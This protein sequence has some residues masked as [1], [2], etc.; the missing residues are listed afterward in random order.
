MRQIPALVAAFAMA[1]V[2]ALPAKAESPDEIAR[3]QSIEKSQLQTDCLNGTTFRAPQPE[4]ARGLTRGLDSPAT[5]CDTYAA[6]PADVL[7]KSAGVTFDK[8]KPTLAIPACESATKQ[9]PNSV[10]LIYQL[11]RA[12]DKSN[13]VGAAIVQYRRAAQRGYTLAQNA[14]GYI[15][16]TGERGFPKNEKLADDWYRKAAEGGLAQAQ[17]TLGSMYAD[18]RGVA[19]DVKQAAVWYRKSA[20]QGY[21]LAQTLLGGMYFSG[22]GV[23]RDIEQAYFWFRKA[24][25]QGEPSAQAIVGLRYANGDGV[26]KDEVQAIEWSRKAAVQGNAG[27]Q[28]YLGQRYEFGTNQDYSQAMIWYRK[29]ADQGYASAQLNLGAMYMNGKGVSIDQAQALFWFRK[30]ADQGN[31]NAQH[32]MGVIYGTGHGVPQDYVEAMRWYLLAANQGFPDAQ[33]N[34]SALYFNGWGVPEDKLLA[35]AW[36]RKAAKQGYQLAK[37]KLPEFELAIEKSKSDQANRQIE[38]QAK[39]L[40]DQMVKI[41]NRVRACIRLNIPAAYQAGV[42]GFDQFTSFVR[43][44]CFGVFAAENRQVW[45]GYNDEMGNAEFKALVLQEVAP[46]EW[47]RQMDQGL[48]R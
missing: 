3:C 34:I 37:D 40:T 2:L 36:L 8:L 22:E 24:A 30:A 44:R 45:S 33:Y 42:Y 12:Y 43:A 31:A 47:K 10:R 4:A 28:Y 38:I 26:I 9:Y 48:K 19:K 18:G 14:L 17:V 1:S 29:A 27:A 5:D 41:G 35:L 46:D 39:A 13:I 23:P 16:D 6:N 7:R 21:P 15:Y 25:E 20:E 11:G 32:A